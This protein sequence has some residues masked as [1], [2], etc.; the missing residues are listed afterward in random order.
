M[1]TVSEEAVEWIEQVTIQIEDREKDQCIT[2]SSSSE[3]ILAG[4]S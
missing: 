1:Q 3:F 2:P 4:A